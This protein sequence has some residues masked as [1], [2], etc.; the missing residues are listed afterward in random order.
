[1][2]IGGG[3]Q[4]TGV[5]GEAPR[6]T[7]SDHAPNS[8]VFSNDR[9]STAPLTSIIVSAAGAL[10]AL[11]IM[12]INEEAEKSL[13]SFEYEHLDSMKSTRQT[14]IQSLFIYVKCNHRCKTYLL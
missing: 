9:G 12:K 10:L 2:F 11:L 4:T 6:N 5:W 7:F 1:M 14:S 13:H 8:I 3:G